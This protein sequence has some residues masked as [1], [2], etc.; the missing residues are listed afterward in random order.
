MVVAIVL[1]RADAARVLVDGGAKLDLK[2]KKGDSSD[3]GSL[4]RTNGNGKDSP[5]KRNGP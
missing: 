5:R 1:G 2:S 3:T 4:F